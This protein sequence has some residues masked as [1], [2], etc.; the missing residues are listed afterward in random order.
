MRYGLYCTYNLRTN[1]KEGDGKPRKCTVDKDTRLLRYGSESETT[2][3][4]FVLPKAECLDRKGAAQEDNT[5]NYP[6]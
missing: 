5:I 4:G 2:D 3:L 1:D 6:P